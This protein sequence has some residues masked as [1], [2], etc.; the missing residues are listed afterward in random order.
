[1]FVKPNFK[2]NNGVTSRLNKSKDRFNWIN[3]KY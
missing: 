1:M 2:E 3:L